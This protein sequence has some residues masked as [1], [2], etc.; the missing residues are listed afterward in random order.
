MDDDISD[1]DITEVSITDVK[2]RCDSDEL[3]VDVS[4]AAPYEDGVILIFFDCYDMEKY[5]NE[6]DLTGA[7]TYDFSGEY[8]IN[9]SFNIE[10][11]KMK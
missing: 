4:G 3:K 10:G 8:E 11:A 9:V 6:E 7:D 5:G 1:L 2:V